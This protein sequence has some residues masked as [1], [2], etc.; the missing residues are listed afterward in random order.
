MS[1]VDSLDIVDQT[2]YGI[3]CGRVLISELLYTQIIEVNLFAFASF[4][5]LFYCLLVDSS[6]LEMD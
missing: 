1:F 2:Y 5:L 6:E 4:C 3:T